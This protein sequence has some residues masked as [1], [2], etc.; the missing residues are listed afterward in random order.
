MNSFLLL[1]IMIVPIRALNRMSI[2]PHYI[3][4]DIPLLGVVLVVA[5]Y[6]VSQ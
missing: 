5:V 1:H 2:R 3:H 4:T 6:Y